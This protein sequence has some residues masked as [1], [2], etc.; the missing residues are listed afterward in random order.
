MSANS[1]AG[2]LLKEAF[3]GLSVIAPTYEQALPLLEGLVGLPGSAEADETVGTG[4]GQPPF[5]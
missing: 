1:K 2:L 3:A 4:P 5:D